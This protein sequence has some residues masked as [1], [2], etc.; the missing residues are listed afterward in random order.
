MIQDAQ[1]HRLSGATDEAVT[2]YNDAIRAFILV[3]GDAIGQ[4]DT[5]RRAA[6]DAVS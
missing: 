2:A 5:A 4:F 1:E 6:P 3:H